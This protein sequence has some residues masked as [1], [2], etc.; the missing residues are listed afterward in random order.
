MKVFFA[1][2]DSNEPEQKDRTECVELDP[3]DHGDNKRRAQKDQQDIQQI[4]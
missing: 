4:G 1:E 2:E 3:H